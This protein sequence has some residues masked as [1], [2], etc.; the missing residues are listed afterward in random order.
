MK[1][2]LITL[3]L[4]GLSLTAWTQT[5]KILYQTFSISDTTRIVQLDI[6]GEME[7]EPWPADKLM[8]ETYVMLEGAPPNVMDFFV[9]QGR[10]ALS[11]EGVETMEVQSQDK[12]RRKIE[13]KGTTCFEQVK[14]K[15][16]IPKNFE[17][18]EARNALI[19]TE[20]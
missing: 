4:L 1:T 19:R 14:V 8:V 15:I 9:E 6:V 10:Y 7:Y 2:T 12:E 18:D 17:L 16:F 3:L 13:Y 11:G 5:E 20:E